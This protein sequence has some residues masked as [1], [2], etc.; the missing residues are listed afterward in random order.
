MSV[1][2]LNVNQCE[3]LHKKFP[4]PDCCICNR[5]TK[6]SE[7]EEEIRNLKEIIKPFVAYSVEEIDATAADNGHPRPM[8]VN[9]NT[10]QERAAAVAVGFFKRER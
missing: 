7:L 3:W 8:S 2:F 10:H 4:P 5:D 6:I 9:I 1:K